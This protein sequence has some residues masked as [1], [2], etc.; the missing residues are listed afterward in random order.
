[1]MGD[2]F[3][4]DPMSAD[5]V[6][7][8]Y[9]EETAAE[10][11]EPLSLVQGEQTDSRRE[12]T[13]GGR[14]FGYAG[15]IVSILALFIM[16]VLLGIAGVALGFIARG[17]GAEGLGAWAIGIGAAAVVMGLFVLPFF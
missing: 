7:G 12:R 6:K 1:M 5:R 16:P 15:L 11:A 2:K 14:G 4:K 10:L 8:G 3:D 13:E 17:R 9:K